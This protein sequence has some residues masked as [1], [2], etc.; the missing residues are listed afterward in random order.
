MFSQ[1]LQ[2]IFW[3]LREWW[4]EGGGLS[5][6]GKK[7]TFVMKIFFSDNVEWSSENLWKMISADVKA[8][9]NNKKW[10]PV[11]KVSKYGDIS[12]SYFIS[13]QYLSV[14]SPNTGKYGPEF[15]HFSCS[16]RS[17]NCILQFFIRSTF[18][19][20]NTMEKILV[21]ILFILILS[22]GNRG[23][24]LFLLNGQNPLSVTKVI[25]DSP[26]KLEE[27]KFLYI[28]IEVQLWNF[29]LNRWSNQ[30]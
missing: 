10:N 15:R 29:N 28:E 21:S 13:G 12:G 17:S 1:R 23:V 4:F 22:A 8:N 26:L 14:F 2:K 25:V 18:K 9:K 30:N 3:L 7:E 11:W 20:R 5:E 19:T 6:S 24:G 27:N 16:E